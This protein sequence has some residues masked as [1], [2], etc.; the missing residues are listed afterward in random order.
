[1]VRALEDTAAK[2]AAAGNSSIVA[3][4]PAEAKIFIYP[5][6]KFRIVD[7]MLTNFHLPRSSLLVLVAAFAGRD[8]ALAAYDHALRENYRFYSYGDCMLIR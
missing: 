8:H 5:G 6:H 4:G 7:Q 2:S 1:M 3:P